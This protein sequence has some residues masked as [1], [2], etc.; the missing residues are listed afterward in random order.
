M[1]QARS[2]HEKMLCM[3]NLSVGRPEG[4]DRSEDLG[5]CVGGEG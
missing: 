1:G 3:Y 4:R 5:V 2:T